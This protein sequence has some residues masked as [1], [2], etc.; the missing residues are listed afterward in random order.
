VG[1]RYAG[2][3][4][5]QV[6]GEMAGWAPGTTIVTKPEITNVKLAQSPANGPKTSKMDLS[7]LAEEFRSGIVSGRPV[8]NSQ[9]DT[10][11]A[12]EEYFEPESGAAHHK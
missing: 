5:N 3:K 8:H 6:P 12:T 9:C 10:A 11:G 7:R 2:E 4:N 1:G